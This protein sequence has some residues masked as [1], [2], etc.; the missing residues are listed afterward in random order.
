MVGKNMFDD[1]DR[2][3]NSLM[4]HLSRSYPSDK[5]LLYHRPEGH[6]ESSRDV[7]S[8]IFETRTYR[9]RLAKK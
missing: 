2:R 5:D 3:Y 6:F 9:S 4:G 1:G 8:T 7:P